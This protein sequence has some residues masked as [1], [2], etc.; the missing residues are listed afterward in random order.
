MH[1]DKREWMRFPIDMHREQIITRLDPAVRWTFVEMNGEARI[2]R[3]DGV[4]ERD[5]AEFLWPVEHLTALV[6]SHPVD[7]LVSFADE[8]YVITKY[9]K[10]QFT[11][12]DREDLR[13]KRAAAGAAGG[14]AKASSSKGLASAKQTLASAKQKLANASKAK[15]NLAESESESDKELK[16]YDLSSQSG[17]SHV[18]RASDFD[19]TDGIELIQWMLE[20]E[21][22]IPSPTLDETE[23]W[24]D[25]VLARAR[26]RVD[27]PIGYLKRVIERTP[28]E[29]N[30]WFVEYRRNQMRAVSQ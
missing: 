29:I 22:L 6:K 30:A 18:T 24:G 20:H 9:A 11:E 17:L 25:A 23:A 1:K 19:S 12:A 15:Q 16:D 5:H 28:D 13:A 8:K 26:G 4:F 14:K 7:P 21:V 3:N 10:H 27:K 2:E